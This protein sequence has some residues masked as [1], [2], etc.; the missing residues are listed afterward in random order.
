MALLSLEAGRAPLADFNRWVDSLVANYKREVDR[1]VPIVEEDSWIAHIVQKEAIQNSADALEEP[2]C[3]DKLCVTFQMDDALPPKFIA[4][5]DQGTCGLT[6]KALVL[7]EELDKLEE[8]DPQKY[9]QERWARFE[10]LSFP[11]IDPVGRGSR[12]QGKWAFIGASQEKTI[13]YDTFRKDGVY[14]VSGWLGERQ[15]L[16]KPL[17]GHQAE[18]LIEKEFNLTQLEG[19]GTRIIIKNP[20]KELW[21]GFLEF[22]KSPI[23]KYIGETWWELLKNGASIFLKWRGYSLKVETPAIYRDDFI[24]KNAEETWVLRNVN[25]NWPKNPKANIKE[26]V[27]ILCKNIIPEG[28]RGIAIQ[29]NGMKIRNFDVQIENPAITKEIADRIYGWITFNEDGEKELR[30]IEDT[31]HYDFSSSLGTFGI[32]VFGRSGWLVQ[33]VRKF[34]EQKLGLGLKDRGKSERLDILA[35]NRLNKFSS[36]YNLGGT[37]RT[38]ITGV[39]PTPKPPE[40][41][42]IK[43]PKPVFPHI[44]TRRVEYGE[45]VTDIQ[46]SVVNNSDISRKMVLALILKTASR[47]I[48]ERNLKTFVSQEVTV[49]AHGKSPTFGP[50]TVS[51][52]K[53]KF[54]DGTYALEAE[55]VLLEGDVLDEK[56]GKGMVIDQERELVYLNVDPPTGKGLFEFIDRVDFEEKEKTLQYRLKEKDEKYRIQIN[57]LHPAYKHVEE[58]DDLLSEQKFYTKTDVPNPLLDYEIEIGA[59]A[60]AHYDLKKGEANLIKDEKTRKNFIDQRNKDE[61]EFFIEVMDRASRIAQEIRHEV[62]GGT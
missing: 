2:N 4:V 20:R 46:V 42:R 27:I 36:K 52:S 25:V 3:V 41:I 54:R 34:A 30:A 53:D 16:Q 35:V 48:P 1:N 6:G 50:F 59:E 43:M 61:K 21:E 44:E 47:K 55:I 29:R 19:V 38:T 9:Q 14:R 60:I 32:H 8:T 10:A 58:I 33:E 7:K 28:F 12:G 40:D 57:T 17:E 62:L 56:F 31:T 45:S 11:N 15:L 39:K 13:I 37:G 18:E 49:D 23:A 5:T 22:H 51:F 24:E 26:L